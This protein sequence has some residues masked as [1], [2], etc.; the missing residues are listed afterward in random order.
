MNYYEST[1]AI[2]KTETYL[3]FL[4][5]ILWNIPF[6]RTVVEIDDLKLFVFYYIC[7][8]IMTR[9]FLDEV[10]LEKEM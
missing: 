3:S 6:A 4:S 5:Y 1:N 8:G 9:S 10:Y 2:F 7:M